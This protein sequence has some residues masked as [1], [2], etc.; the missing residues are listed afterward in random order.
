MLERPNGQEPWRER[1]SRWNREA[2]CGM[3]AIRVR[4]MENPRL[5]AIGYSMGRGGGGEAFQLLDKWSTGQRHTPKGGF[6]SLMSGSSRERAR[7]PASYMWRIQI[8]EGCG[9]VWVVRPSRP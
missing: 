9:K 2:S 3:M 4:Q 7:Q 8:M 1:D 5:K 6:S